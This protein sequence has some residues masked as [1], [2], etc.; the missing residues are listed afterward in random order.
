MKECFAWTLHLFFLLLLLH[1]Y[2]AGNIVIAIAATKYD[3]VDRPNIPKSSLVP[4]SQAR[5]LAKSIDAIF[6]DTSARNDENVNLLFQKVAERVLL[7]REQAKNRRSDVEGVVDAI[8]VTPRASMNE[9]GKVGKGHVRSQEGARD[10]MNGSSYG[11][12]IASAATLT[13]TTTPTTT[14]YTSSVSSSHTSS[15]AFGLNLNHPI[16][17]LQRESPEKTV[18]KIR[19]NGNG[20]TAVMDSDI[21]LDE[22]PYAD[23]TKS[24]SVGLC[25]GPLMECS[26]SKGGMSCTIC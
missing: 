3:L 10:G 16:H 8:P 18:E 20:Q 6:V 7:V 4:P 21:P 19:R 14:A 22:V 5:E 24:S 9:N 2:I 17:S 26:S 12:D 1:L 11:N 25:M 13:N 23:T 15:S